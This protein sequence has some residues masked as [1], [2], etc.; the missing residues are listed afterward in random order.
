MSYTHFT[1]DTKVQKTLSECH[2]FV[3]WLKKSTSF[4]MHFPEDGR[5]S[6]RKMFFFLIIQDTLKSLYVFVAFVIVSNQLN[7]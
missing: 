1:L 2:T 7:A 5:L 4:V 3:H 6:G